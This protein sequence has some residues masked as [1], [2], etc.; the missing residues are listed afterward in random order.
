MKDFA[1]FVKILDDEVYP[2]IELIRLVT[3]NLNTYKEKAFYET[4]SFH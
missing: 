3:D 1:R 4:F 2:N